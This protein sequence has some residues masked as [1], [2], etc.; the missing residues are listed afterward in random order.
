MTGMVEFS[1]TKR[2]RLSPPRGMRQWTSVSSLRR[3]LSA[4]RFVS[5]DE[6]DG[7]GGEAGGGKRGGDER[8]EG[9][10]GVEAFLAAAEDGGVAGLQAENGAVDG[11]VGAG[12]VDDADDADGHA[13]L[14]DVEAV[15]AGGFL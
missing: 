5:G 3:T 1:A 2:M 8:G 11:D 4:A 9:G 7:V 13:D 6:L 10:V 15:G 12:L 14:A